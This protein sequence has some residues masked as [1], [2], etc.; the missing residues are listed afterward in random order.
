M[1]L[2][3]LNLGAGVQSTALYLMAIDGELEF[4]LAIFADTGDEP[5][6]VYDHLAWLKTLG[7]PEIIEV[8]AGNLGE[9]LIKGVASGGYGGRRFASIPTFLAVDGQR[10]GIG[11][12]QCTSDF[13]IAPI[14]K[15]IRTRLGAG[16]G[17]R[18]PKGNT[19]VQTFGLSFDEPKRV[20]RV[21]DQFRGSYYKSAEFPLFDWFMTRQDCV[22]YL[23]KRVPD[24][25]IPR[26]ACV[27]CPYHSDDEWLRIK[28]D[29]EA[30][31][32]AVEIDN[33]IRDKT[34]ACTRGMVAEQFL[35]RSCLPLVQ[36]DFKPRPPNQTARF[37]FVDRDCEGMCG[38]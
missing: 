10:G 38:L 34:S 36:I 26:S 33:A 27:Y 13:K 24:R 20:S 11:R 8:T 25:E 35:H 2:R 22:A 16:H 4:D 29:P 7:G 12:R 3:V 6:S 30:W 23:K 21:R 15:E 37:E 14:E 28:S 32:R 31:A 1:N 18:V 5:R 9:N 17:E 19:V